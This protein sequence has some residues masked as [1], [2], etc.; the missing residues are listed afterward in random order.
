MRRAAG[1]AVSYVAAVVGAGFAS[2]RELE[3]FF[4][5]YGCWGLAGAVLAGLLFAAFG[6]VV[7]ATAAHLRPC[8]YGALIRRLCG[9]VLGAALDH[10][11]FL[12]LLASLAVVL[13]GG[14]ALGAWWLSWPRALS[15]GLLVLLLAATQWL[16]SPAY[17]AVAL[18]VIPLIGASVLIATF[19]VHGAV[20]RPLWHGAA[21]WPVPAVLYVAYNLLLGT[22]GLASG[23]SAALTPGEGFWGGVAGGAVLGLLCVSAVWALLHHPL[24]GAELPL[25]SSLPPGLWYAVGYPLTML[26]ALWTTGAACLRSLGERLGNGRASVLALPL[27]WP[28][29]SVGLVTV[30]ARVYPALGWLGVPLL[31]AAALAAPTVRA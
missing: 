20:G 25:A 4:V 22:A 14:A 3:H 17:T 7:G 30:V 13:A 27:V 10:L 31:I 29:A 5:A 12:V 1:L 8:H 18:A 6:G 15:I 28:L 2:G 9:N 23:T 19:A 26:L 11:G 24:P 16:G 21:A